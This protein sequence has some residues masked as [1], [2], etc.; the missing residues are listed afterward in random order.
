MRGKIPAGP[1][2]RIRLWPLLA[3][4]SVI[5]FVVAFAVG[6]SDP[7]NKLGSATGTSVTVMIATIAFFLFAVLGA[8]TAIRERATPMNRANYWY[9]SVSAGL[10]LIVALYLLSYGVIGIMTWA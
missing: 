1:A 7:F 6:F 3:S 4:L 8:Y 10:H 5:V 9:C 2:I